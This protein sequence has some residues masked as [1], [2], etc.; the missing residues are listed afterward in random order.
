MH[1]SDTS[2]ADSNRR[3]VIS[4][5]ILLGLSIL[6]LPL[7]KSKNMKANDHARVVVRSEISLNT[8]SVTP[9]PTSLDGL[10]AEKKTEHGRYRDLIARNVQLGNLLERKIVEKSASRLVIESHW[11]SMRA[12]QE[13]ISSTEVRALLYSFPSDLNIREFRI[14]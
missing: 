12:Y 6:G 11:V 10:L 8:D 3:Q 7:F 5:G 13:Y 2:D 1:A 9:L 14:S 4:G